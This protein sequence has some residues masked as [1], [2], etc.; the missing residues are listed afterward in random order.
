LAKNLNLPVKIDH[1]LLKRTQHLP[2]QVGLSGNLRKRNLKNAFAVNKS[3][4][5]K[6]IAIVDDVI[7]TGSTVQ[8]IALQ[9]K[10]AGARQ[11]DVWAVLRA[12]IH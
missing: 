2:S 10:K 7:T 5:D 6:H 8:A 12:Q 11:V 9:L 1:H 3:V 4:R